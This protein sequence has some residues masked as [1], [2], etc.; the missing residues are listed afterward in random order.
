L[1]AQ[2]ATTAASL[3]GRPLVRRSAASTSAV[4]LLDRLLHH[5]HVVVT[6][7]ESYRMREAR[8]SPTSA[9]YPSCRPTTRPE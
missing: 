2:R 7:G 9:T 4:S 3:P 5:T 1:L 8:T 6:D